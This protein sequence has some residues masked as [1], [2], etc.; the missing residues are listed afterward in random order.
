MPAYSWLW[1]APSPILSSWRVLGWD[2]EAHITTP[3]A[4]HHNHMPDCVLDSDFLVVTLTLVYRVCCSQRW[5]DFFWNTVSCKSG[6]LFRFF[7]SE[8]E[9]WQRHWRPGIQVLRAVGR[10]RTLN[11]SIKRISC[12]KWSSAITFLLRTIDFRKRYQRHCLFFIIPIDAVVRL[13]AVEKKKP[14]WTSQPTNSNVTKHQ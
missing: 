5:I 6:S 4:G 7:L 12:E 1:F 11:S 3:I 10:V 9:D 8:N 14:L 2:A 13:G